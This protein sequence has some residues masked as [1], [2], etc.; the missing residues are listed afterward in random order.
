[1]SSA[2]L[3]MVYSIHLH[4][5]G[6]LGPMSAKSVFHLPC[7]LPAI[8]YRDVELSKRWFLL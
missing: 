6:V 2:G 3:N 7:P 8:G 1:M 4:E 5:P